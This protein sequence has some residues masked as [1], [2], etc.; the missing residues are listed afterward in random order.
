MEQMMPSFVT[1]MAK[2]QNS[3]SF[4]F[5]REAIMRSVPKKEIAMASTGLID[6][7][8]SISGLSFAP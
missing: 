4:G 6:S 8:V 1:A 3:Q 5:F 2:V 7:M